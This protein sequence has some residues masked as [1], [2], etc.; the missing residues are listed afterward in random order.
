MPW[1]VPAAI[2]ALQHDIECQPPA[3]QQQTYRRLAIQHI[4]ARPDLFLLRT[5]NRFRAFFC[6]P[7]HRGEPL[8]GRANVFAIA[9][10]AGPGNHVVGTLLLLAY[11]DAGNHLLLQSRR[12]PVL[13]QRMRPSCSVQPSSTP[14]PAFS[15]ARSRATTSRS[16]LCSPS[17]PASFW[18]RS[19]TNHGENCFAPGT[20]RQ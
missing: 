11:H 14:S 16:C 9:W 19:S 13:I 8:T 4:S 6:F 15:P 7:I 18:T 20:S 2:A 12:I 1:S 17:S 5:F 3:Q 10:M